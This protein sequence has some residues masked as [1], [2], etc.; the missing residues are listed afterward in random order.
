MGPIRYARVPQEVTA[1]SDDAV[2]STAGAVVVPESGDVQHCAAALDDR[3]IVFPR[4]IVT[5]VRGK[6]HSV[7]VA[8][9]IVGGDAPVPA[10][11]EGVV[12][13]F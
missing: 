9:R 2:Y 12:G 10:R 8:E 13:L 11:T 1:S 7:V 5:V 3:V 6:H 4:V